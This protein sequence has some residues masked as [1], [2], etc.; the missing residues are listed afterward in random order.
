MSAEKKNNKNITRI[1]N[2]DLLYDAKELDAM[3]N[4]FQVQ[5]A[6]SVS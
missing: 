3:A 2:L 6:C 4:K 1:Q 5:M